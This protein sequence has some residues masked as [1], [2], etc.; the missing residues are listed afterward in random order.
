MN[1]N[2]KSRIKL[3]KEKND[4]IYYAENTLGFKLNK[5]QKSLLKQYEQGYVILCGK[6]LKGKVVKEIIKKHKVLC[7]GSVKEVT[8]TE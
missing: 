4:I 6:G 2:D 8:I 7:R 5:S 3:S 1:T